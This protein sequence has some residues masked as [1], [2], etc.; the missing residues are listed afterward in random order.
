MSG[1]TQEELGALDEALWRLPTV[2]DRTGLSEAEILRRE[3]HGAFPPR[4]RIGERAVAWLASEVIRWMREQPVAG[5]GVALNPPPRSRARRSQS[6]LRVL[7]Q[8]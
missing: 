1:V 2:I 7:P 5:R 6:Q 3:R 8:G 4:R